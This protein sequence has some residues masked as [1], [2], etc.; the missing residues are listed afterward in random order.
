M[1]F[2]ISPCHRDLGLPAGLPVRGFRLYI[3]FT[4]LVT[5]RWLV[6]YI[7]GRLDYSYANPYVEYLLLN[8]K[9]QQYTIGHLSNVHSNPC[10]VN[11]SCL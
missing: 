8:D 10:L 6:M 11:Y 1:S 2:L 7:F 4:T 9:Q 5:S 3:F